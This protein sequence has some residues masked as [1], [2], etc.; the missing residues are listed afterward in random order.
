[1][2]LAVDKAV[3]L[4][5]SDSILQAG[6][7]GCSTTAEI[8]VNACGSSHAPAYSPSELIYLLGKSDS[9][10]I[11]IRAEVGRELQTYVGPGADDST[12][13]VRAHAHNQDGYR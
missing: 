8:M 4:K 13:R 6:W 1:M 7:A 3:I 10:N 11:K 9:T 2:S 12:N 5:G